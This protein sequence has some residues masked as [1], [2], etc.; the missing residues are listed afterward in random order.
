MSK[1]L[2]HST[3][4]AGGII[5]NCRLF[6]T[7]SSEMSTWFACSC[8]SFCVSKTLMFGSLCPLLSQTSL[9]CA[10]TFCSTQPQG[11]VIQYIPSPS[12]RFF[13]FVSSSAAFGLAPFPFSFISFPFDQ[14]TALINANSLSFPRLKWAFCL[15][16]HVSIC[17]WTYSN[18]SKC[19]VHI[20]NHQLF[21]LTT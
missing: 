20:Q 3:W 6:W 2:V 18:S 17:Q 8:F 7:E 4:R 5:R 9:C 19:L 10:T 14:R 11:Y 1:S 12:A 15:L 21:G 13:A 16:L